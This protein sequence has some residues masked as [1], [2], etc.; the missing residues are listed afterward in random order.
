MDSD[1]MSNNTIKVVLDLFCHTAA[2][3]IIWSDGGSQFTSS[4]FQ[5]FLKDW[6]VS[7]NISSP[8]YHHSNG[9][10]ESTIKSMKKLIKAAWRRRSVDQDILSRSLLQYR[11]TLCRRDGRSSAQM[12]YGHLVQDSLPMHRRS[13]APE[14]QRPIN[15]EHAN[16]VLQKAESFYDQHAHTLSDLAPG[17]HV[18]VQNPASKAWDIY[19]Y[20]VV[21]A[22]SPH[23][24]YFIRTQS[25]KVLVRNRRFLHKR[26]AILVHTPVEPT[27]VPPDLQ[28]HVSMLGHLCPQIWTLA[29]W[30]LDVQ[31]ARDVSWLGSLRMLLELI[32]ML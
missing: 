28:Q 15:T 24:W 3:D 8:H 21:S 25:G 9:K 26:T 16:D 11:N 10:A 29:S 22:V 1:I 27:Q 18:A 13:F 6:G 5:A 19:M 17:T 30:L 2:P 7:H 4:R 31:G 32:K 12:L 20:R 23:R 14:W